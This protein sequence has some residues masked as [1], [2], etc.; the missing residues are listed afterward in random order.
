ML[1]GEIRGPIATDRGYHVLKVDKRWGDKPLPLERIAP[2]IRAKL[3]DLKREE[4][5]NEFI[6]SLRGDTFI[7]RAD[8]GKAPAEGR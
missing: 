7:E 2:E 5:Y 8:L 6:E 1:E 4:R 3:L